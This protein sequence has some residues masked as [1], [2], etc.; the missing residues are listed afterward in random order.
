MIAY[1]IEM[2]PTMQTTD[3]FAAWKAMHIEISAKLS[4]RQPPI[5][6]QTY[7]AVRSPNML[8][9]WTTAIKIRIAL[10]MITPCTAW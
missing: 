1:T 6:I 3:V 10:M 5:R 9:S 2:Y 4:A 8:S 7:L